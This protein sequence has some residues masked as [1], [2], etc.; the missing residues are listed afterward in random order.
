[1]FEFHIS[2]CELLFLLVRMLES[3]FPALFGFDGMSCVQWVQ[4]IRILQW[5][6]ICC[7]SA[8]QWLI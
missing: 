8:R 3:G 7:G 5:L 2:Q 1:M 6:H 4:V